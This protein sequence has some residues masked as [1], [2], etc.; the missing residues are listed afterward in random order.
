MRFIPTAG[1]SRSR[2]QVSEN[3]FEQRRDFYICK[4]YTDFFNV[5]R[6]FQEVYQLYR[7]CR[8][9]EDKA[10]SRS[11][12][13]QNINDRCRVWGQLTQ[14]VGTEVD[15]GPLWELKDL[16]HRLWPKEV[17]PQNPEG[18]LIDW[19]IGSIFHEAMKLKENVYILNSYNTAS[20]QTSDPSAVVLQQEIAA[21]LLAEVMWDRSLTGRIVADV[22]KQMEQLSFLLGHANYMLRTM[23]SG[24]SRNLLLVRLLAGQEKMV[25]EL[26]GEGVVPLFEDMFFGA[27]KEGFCAAGRSFMAGQWYPQALKMYQQALDIDRSCD[28]A[29]VKVY[30]LKA[31]IRQNST[32]SGVGQAH[33]KASLDK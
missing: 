4:L 26:W 30:Q 33:P 22:V 32:L 29:V 23:T 17:Q 8:M 16:C 1:V 27:P 12:S 28:E 19:L 2:R 21:S 6:T 13:S 18:S 25:Q 9:F 5:I 11:Q 10:C 31:M 3:W 20:L 14:M 15:K 24:Q 7:S